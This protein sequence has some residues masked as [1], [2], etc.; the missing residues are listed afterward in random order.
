MFG[1]LL[2]GKKRVDN[3][4][5]EVGVMDEFPSARQKKINLC[6]QSAYMVCGEASYEYDSERVKMKLLSLLSQFLIKIYTLFTKFTPYLTENYKEFSLK[7]SRK[8]K[9]FF[10]LWFTMIDEFI[11]C[12]M[13]LY[14]R[15]TVGN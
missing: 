12:I 1:T 7:L 14:S 2:K 5:K 11:A 8:S 10:Q 13:C 4:R 9:T 3:G 15:Y 6:L